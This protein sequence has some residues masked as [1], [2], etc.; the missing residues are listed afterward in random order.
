MHAGRSLAAAVPGA[1]LLA[2]ALV[3]PDAGATWFVAVA[4][5]MSIALAALFGVPMRAPL[6]SSRRRRWTS[7]ALAL[8]IG[9]VG[10][11][12]ATLLEPS[13]G[14]DG[15]PAAARAVVPLA[16]GM[17]V[18]GALLGAHV[19]PA[20][21]VVIPRGTWWGA[22]ALGGALPWAIESA[23]ITVGYAAYPWA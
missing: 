23:A 21:G 6:A 7:F 1:V 10:V 5:A 3:V 22:L 15:S 17:A 20:R 4:Y 12:A 19:G 18:G 16:L 13:W 9:L 11:T 8:G 14:P 2:V